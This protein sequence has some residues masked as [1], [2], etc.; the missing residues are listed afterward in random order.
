MQKS[1]KTYYRDHKC[2]YWNGSQKYEKW[3]NYWSGQLASVEESEKNWSEFS[4]GSIEQDHWWREDPRDTWKKASWY[5]SSRIKETSWTADTA[6]A[7][8]QRVMHDDTCE[9]VWESTVQLL[10]K[11]SKLNGREMYLIRRLHLLSYINGGKCVPKDTSSNLS[12]GKIVHLKKID[13]SPPPPPSIW[14]PSCLRPISTRSPLLFSH[15]GTFNRLINLN[16]F[17]SVIYVTFQWHAA[18]NDIP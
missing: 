17:I 4:E 9:S 8:S 3:E 11:R 5:P 12:G 7:S 14:C 13:L 16:V 18:I 15:S 6:R 2:R 1:M 10:H